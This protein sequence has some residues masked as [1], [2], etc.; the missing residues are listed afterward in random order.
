MHTEGQGRV[1]RFVPPV[2]VVGV[3]G[4]VE[5]VRLEPLGAPPPVEAQVT[6]EEGGAHL[7][8]QVRHRALCAQ[9]PHPRVHERVAG[10]AQCPATEERAGL[11]AVGPPRMR[12]RVQWPCTR[13]E[14]RAPTHAR[15]VEKV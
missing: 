7:A 8:E 10:A 12:C 13:E 15:E 9:L 3:R 2:A 5:Q 6:H 4:V 1:G 14:R 11:G